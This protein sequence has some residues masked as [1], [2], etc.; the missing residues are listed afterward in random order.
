MT[1]D[2]RLCGHQKSATINYVFIPQNHNNNNNELKEP[3][4]DTVDLK[5]LFGETNLVAKQIAKK[6][7]NLARKKPFKKPP[8]AA[9]AP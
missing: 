6:C 9:D 2:C 7:R 5:Q 3:V 1:E 8:P 4:G